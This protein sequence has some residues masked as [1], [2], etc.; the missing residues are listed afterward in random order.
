MVKIRQFVLG[1]QLNACK[2]RAGDSR[3]TF[4]HQTTS[5]GDI[6]AIQ[7]IIQFCPDSVL[8]LDNQKRDFLDIV[9]TSGHFEKL[10]IF[11]YDHGKEDNV[12]RMVSPYIFHHLT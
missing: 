2:L 12:L 3:W 10:G 8:V 9:I 1:T 11:L 7:D 6:G 4:L 5:T